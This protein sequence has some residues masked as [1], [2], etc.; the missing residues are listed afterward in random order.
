MILFIAVFLLALSIHYFTLLSRPWLPYCVPILGHSFAM[1][2]SPYNLVKDI[3]LTSV[4]YTLTSI[5][6]DY[7]SNSVR[8]RLPGL[9]PCLVQGTRNIRQLFKLTLQ[10]NPGHAKL[11]I[12][13]R[14]FGMPI[15]AARTFLEDKSGYSITPLPHSNVEERNRICYRDRSILHSILQGSESEML[16][17]R[18]ITSFEARLRA[19]PIDE[20]W[21]EFPDLFEFF[22]THVTPASIE[23]L[24]GPALA[25]TIDPDFVR[26]FWKFDHWVPMMAKRAPTWLF[27]EAYRIRDHLVDSIKRWRLWS[28]QTRDN[29]GGSRSMIQKNELLD[30]DGWD[31]HAIAA[32]DLGLIWA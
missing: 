24:C 32:S 29:V 27:P 1:L 16:V 12:A 22:T 14:V 25:T 26:D 31:V 28:G 18:F 21:I 9:N 23:A 11:F 4:P 5:H 13:G 2:I 17:E 3:R 15:S 8:L 20:H 19:L 30:V 7:L 6:A 10:S